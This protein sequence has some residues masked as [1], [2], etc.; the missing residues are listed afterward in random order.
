[1]S[2][3]S[4]LSPRQIEVLDPGPLT[5]V[6]DLGR[7]G[8]AHLGVGTSGACDRAAL[9]LANRLV[10]NAEA[11]AGLELT[12]G[13]L[14]ARFTAISWLALTGARCD[15]QVGQRAAPFGL[16]FP[17]GAGTVV[18]VGSPAA[19]MRSYLAVRGGVEVPAVLGSRATD[20]L[21]GIGPDPVGPGTILPLGTSTTMDVATLDAVPTPQL[22]EPPVID[23][24]PGPRRS[25]F[26]GEALQVLT[27]VDYHVSP[28]SNRIGIRLSGPPLQRLR[29]DE[30][31]SEGLVTGAVQV[32]SSGQ[33]LI[34]LADHPVTGGY[35]VLAVVRERALPLLAQLRPGQQLS[36]RLS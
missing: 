31:P 2:T 26:A 18:R 3:P 7:P 16:P 19:G 6:Q 35:P 20:L 27:G 17:V 23:I 4:R 36:F 9:R 8:L 25:W 34:F 28:D 1:M 5:T 11:A 10:G 15:V 12:L 33:P 14:V 24:Q 13:G 29:P 21:T 32:T 22:L 30:L